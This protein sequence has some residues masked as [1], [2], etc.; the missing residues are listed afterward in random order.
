MPKSCGTCENSETEPEVA[1]AG[2]VCLMS[3]TETVNLT[4]N[5]IK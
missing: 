3:G 2:I 4:N 5:D 1:P